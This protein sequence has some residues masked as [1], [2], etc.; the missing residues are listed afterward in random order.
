MGITTTQITARRL[1]Q[2]GVAARSISTARRGLLGHVIVPNE[3]LLLRPLAC[4]ASCDLNDRTH[5]SLDKDAPTV[6]AVESKPHPSAEVIARHRL[7]GL[8]HR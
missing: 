4:F 2:I 7:G 1:W 5:L 6:R 3:I 8:H